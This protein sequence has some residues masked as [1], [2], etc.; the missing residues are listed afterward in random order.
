M[1]HAKRYALAGAAFLGWQETASGGH[2]ALYN[3]LRPGSCFGS[4][5]SAAAL[6]DLG[7]AVPETPPMPEEIVRSGKISLDKPDGCGRVV[8]DN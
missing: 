7:I 6:R 4:T 1:Q 5:V 8:P 3:I 2:V